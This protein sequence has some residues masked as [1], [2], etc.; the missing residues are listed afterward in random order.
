MQRDHASGVPEDADVIVGDLFA[1]G[2]ER[3]H[4]RLAERLA[5]HEHVPGIDDAHIGDRRIADIDRRNRLRKL[6]DAHFIERHSDAMRRNNVRDALDR[7]FLRG[8]V[9]HG[10]M[11]RG[12]QLCF[13]VP[14]R[15]NL[16]CLR[17]CCRR[18]LHLSMLRGGLLDLDVLDCGRFSVS[19]GWPL[20]KRTCPPAGSGDYRRGIRQPRQGWPAGHG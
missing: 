1:F 6:N 15:D 10:G 16:L 12:G 13:C 20:R 8:D 4:V 7:R 9:L 14:G 19:G 18:L 3:H 2:I 5:Q 17:M 11:F